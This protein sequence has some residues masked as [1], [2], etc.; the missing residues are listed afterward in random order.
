[1]YVPLFTPKGHGFHFETIQAIEFLY[2]VQ[3]D[4]PHAKCVAS[5]KQP[6]MQERLESGLLADCIEHQRI[7]RFVIN[8]HAFHNAHLLRAT[9]P[10]SLLAPIP[11]HQNREAKHHEIAGSLRVIQESKRRATKARSEQKKLALNDAGQMTSEPKK[12]TRVE[13]EMGQEGLDHSGT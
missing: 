8:T 5:G 3:H 11:L 4:C 10:R 13:Y 9:L 7:D 12:R 2:N 1:M 6:L